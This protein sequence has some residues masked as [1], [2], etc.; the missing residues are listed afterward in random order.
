MNQQKYGR[1]GTFVVVLEPFIFS[2]HQE[3]HRF[4]RH[5]LASGGKNPSPLNTKV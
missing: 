4:E 1:R 3:V 5:A 2:D